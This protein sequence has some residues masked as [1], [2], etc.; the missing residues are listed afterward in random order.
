MVVLSVAASAFTVD[1]INPDNNKVK[2]TSNTTTNVVGYNSV[3]ITEPLSFYNSYG[4]V[5]D[6]YII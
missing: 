4:M 3:N 1:S 5:S 6:I 2:P